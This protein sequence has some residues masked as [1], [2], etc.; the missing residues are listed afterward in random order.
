MSDEHGADHEEVPSPEV[1]SAG[2]RTM[3]TTTRVFVGAWLLAGALALAFISQALQERE[4]RNGSAGEQATPAEQ[5]A[6]TEFPP[7]VVPT[8]SPGQARCIDWPLMS[9]ASREALV[10]TFLSPI[11]SPHEVR[12]ATADVRLACNVRGAAV[13]AQTIASVVRA[14]CRAIGVEYTCR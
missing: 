11:S 3:F 9:A 6:P 12:Q 10:S 4:K 13:D 7:L 14:F 1:P 8:V 2:S 5:V